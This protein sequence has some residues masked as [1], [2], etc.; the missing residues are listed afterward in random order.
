M[1]KSGFAFHCHHDT[2]V[3]YVYDYDERV[4]YIKSDKPEGEQE[5]RLRLFQLIPDERIPKQLLRAGEAYRK[6]WKA[7]RKAWKA[8]RKTGE[9]YRKTGEAYRK[10]GEA[11]RKTGEAYRKTGEACEKVMDKNT[12]Y[13]EEL[14]AELCPDCP[15]DGKTIFSKEEE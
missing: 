14:H 4:A 9:A 8:Y 2:L 13:L 15:W 5:L 12:A 11:Y 7:Y 3:E 10:T 1:R 6:A